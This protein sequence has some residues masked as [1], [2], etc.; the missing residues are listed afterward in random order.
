MTGSDT[1]RNQNNI[2]MAHAAHDPSWL[3]KVRAQLDEVCGPN[4]ERLPEYSDWDK[5][6]YI[7]ATIKETLRIFPNMTQT[8]APHAL[9]Y[10]SAEPFSN[11]RKDDEYNGYH[12]EAGT[13]FVPNHF[14]IVTNPDEYEEPRRFNPDRYD[15]ISRERLIPDS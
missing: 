3:K 2:L 4:A 13:V 8:G 10:Y 14:H 7:H 5:L 9:S 6:P 15:H 11:D 12:F 1:T